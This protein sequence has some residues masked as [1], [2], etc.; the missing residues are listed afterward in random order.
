MLRLARAGVAP[1]RERLHRLG[2]ASLLTFARPTSW[3]FTSFGVVALLAPL[4]DRR[5]T[6]ISHSSRIGNGI[7][8]VRAGQQLDPGDGHGADVKKIVGSLAPV[9]HS[10]PYGTSAPPSIVRPREQGR[11]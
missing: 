4:R 7:E 5:F 3:A 11:P 1:D 8:G 10:L 9:R 6:M 2:E